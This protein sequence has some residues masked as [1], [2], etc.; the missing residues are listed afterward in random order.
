MDRERAIEI[1]N[2]LNNYD[3][4]SNEDLIQHIVN[5]NACPDM[6]GL[7]ARKGLCELNKCSLCWKY[8]LEEKQD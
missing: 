7:C 1:L 2:T 5:Y 4:E 6:F 8:A 3:G